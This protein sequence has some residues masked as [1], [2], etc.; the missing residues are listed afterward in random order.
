MID[1]IHIRFLDILDII[2]VAYLMFEI[3]RWVKGTVALR[4]LIGI[5]G[6]YLFW[7]LVRFFKME[8]LSSILSQ[9]L[10]VGVI[11]LFIVFQQE[12]RK[13]LLMIGSEYFSHNKFSIR[14]WWFK[15]NPT[16]ESRYNIPIDEIIRAVRRMSEKKSGALIAIQRSS[17]LN[18]FI[19]T[20][21][22]LDAICHRHLIETIFFKN[23]A[24]HDGAMIVVQDR[25]AAARCILP[26]SE[27]SDLPAQYGTRHRA[28][29]GL[30]EMTDAIVVVVSEELGSISMA[31]RGQLHY[32]IGAIELRK[33]LE[34]ALK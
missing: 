32:N 3:Y 27:Q 17:S 5:V 10:G 28:A 20:G 1:F 34:Q 19:E 13:F 25:I 2:L 30:S 31:E 8:L 24:L 16:I 15:R 6:L 21:D 11:A 29:L 23:T 7:I 4:I 33:R 9:V 22:L 26:V 18:S 14:R 12:I